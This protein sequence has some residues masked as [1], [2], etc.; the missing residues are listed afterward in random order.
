MDVVARREH[1]GVTED[2]RRQRIVIDKTPQT[3]CV[4]CMRMFAGGSLPLALL[5]GF[6]P[7]RR[8]TCAPG[9]VCIGCVT[10]MEW[11]AYERFQTQHQREGYAE[12]MAAQV[13]KAR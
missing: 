10:R 8:I 2:D 9:S 1:R 4:R 5:N 13:R 6:K 11:K 7:Q 3:L 12:A